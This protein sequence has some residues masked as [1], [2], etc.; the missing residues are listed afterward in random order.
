LSCDGNNLI[1]DAWIQELKSL[2]LM[3]I[4]R[5]LEKVESI[6]TAKSREHYWI[7]HY[8]YL[9]IKTELPLLNQKIMAYQRQPDISP[10]H[11]YQTKL[12]RIRQLRSQGMN[13]S[14]VI[15]LLYGVSKGGSTEYAKARDEYV[16]IMQIIAAE[17]AQAQEGL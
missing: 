6:D 8:Q 10:E 17:D 3:V 13:Q 4:L 14:R 5:T 16:S 7:E 1:K 9:G 11:V 12:S 2:D 15:S